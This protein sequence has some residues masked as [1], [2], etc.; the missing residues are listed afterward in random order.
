MV[1]NVKEL[2]FEVFLTNNIFLY[3]LQPSSFTNFWRWR[4][5]TLAFGFVTIHGINRVRA[6]NN[7]ANLTINDRLFGDHF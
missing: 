7:L 3:I 4:T 1:S 5:T 6:I 2:N